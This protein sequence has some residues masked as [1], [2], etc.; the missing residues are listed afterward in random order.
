MGALFLA[1]RRGREAEATPLIEAT[2]NEVLERGEAYA[3]S[4]AEWARALLYNGL[5]QYEDAMAAA[6]RASAHPEDLWFH[7]FGLV[8]LIE[9][10]VRKGKA[11]QA[12]DALERLSEMTRAGGTD[13]ALGIEARSRALLNEGEAAERLYRE[14]IDRLSRTRVR[15][16][17]GRAHLLF[18]EWLRRERRRLDAREQLRTAHE[19]F[20]GMGVEAFAGR[21][22]RELLA[23]GERARKRTVETREDLTAQEAQIARLARDGLSNPEI[24]ARLFISPRTVE[25]HLGKVFTKLQIGSRIELKRALPSERQTALVS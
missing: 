2:M 4:A 3:V 22:E 14:A 13:W 25:Y 11:E 8:E 20:I 17:L 10:A 16:E 7:N 6:E 15:A 18:G 21:A 1:A 5:G 19:M 23:T 9:A 12:A 24:G